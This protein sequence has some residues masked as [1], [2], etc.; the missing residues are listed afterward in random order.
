MLNYLRQLHSTISY[1]TR[2]W[3]IVSL[4]DETGPDEYHENRLVPCMH[5]GKSLTITTTPIDI[6]FSVACGKDL[7]QHGIF[8]LYSIKSSQSR[9]LAFFSASS[10]PYLLE[11]WAEESFFDLSQ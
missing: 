1:Q 11:A 6:A 7:S 3:E 9:R 8:P 2:A 5:L 10:R 4:R